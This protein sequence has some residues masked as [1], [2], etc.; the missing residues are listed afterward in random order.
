MTLSLEDIMA[1]MQ[2]DK[3]ERKSDREADLEFFREYIL[4][5]VQEQ[6]EVAIKPMQEKQSKLEQEQVV[7][8]NRFQIF[9]RKWRSSKIPSMKKTS[10][11]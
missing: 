6:V 7:M 9:Y 11:T 4:K 2:Q 8:E 1:F 5:G 10:Q 3:I